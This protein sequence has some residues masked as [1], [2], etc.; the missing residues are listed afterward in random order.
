MKAIVAAD[1]NWAIGYQG[2]LLVSIPGD[3]RMFRKET[4]NKVV[5]YGRKT[6]ETFP[7]SQPLE[8]RTNIILSTNRSL[9]VKG[10]VVVHSIEEL[11]DEARQYDTDDVY[12]IGGA[13]VYRQMLPYI[14]TAIVTK[15]DYEYHADVWFP[16][17]DR[18][19]D[20]VMAGE[21][22]EQTYFDVP[23][24]FVTYKRK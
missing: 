17:L 5:V 11:L 23:Y 15:V 13:A 9:S 14:D 3:H 22:E 12:V 20:W 16:N 7:L 10:A 4:L 19:P 21:G 8:K 18:D 6:L 1:R 24:T 2:G